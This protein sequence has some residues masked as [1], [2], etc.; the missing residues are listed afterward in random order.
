MATE[1]NGN[2][3]MRYNTAITAI[4]AFSRGITL[5]NTQTLTWQERATCALFLF[6]SIHTNAHCKVALSR[7]KYNAS[8]EFKYTCKVCPYIPSSH[9]CPVHPLAQMQVSGAEQVPPFWQASLH[10]AVKATELLI[11]YSSDIC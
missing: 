4:T 10:M 2:T 7:S 5:K 9:D 3:Q 8:Q 11:Q 6:P 1:Q